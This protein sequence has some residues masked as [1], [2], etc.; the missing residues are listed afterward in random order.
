[1]LILLFVLAQEPSVFEPEP[2]NAKITLQSG[3]M[4]EISEIRI[5][6][7]EPTTFELQVSGARE[8]FSIFRVSRIRRLEGRQRFEVLLDSGQKIEGTLGSLTFVG[9]EVVEKDTPVVTAGSARTED[10]QAT[11]VELSDVARIHFVVGFQLRSCQEGHYEQYTPYPFCPV[12]GRELVLGPYG[13]DLPEQVLPPA[14]FYRLRLS[15]RDATTR[16]GQ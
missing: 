4:V 2:I 15:P 10:R 5:R 3:E 16:G 12:C 11:R 13:E 1:V 14:P 7:N 8:V 6:G 9:Y